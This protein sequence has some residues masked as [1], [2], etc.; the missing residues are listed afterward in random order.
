MSMAVRSS[1]AMVLLLG[2]VTACS[3]PGAKRPLPP[4][5]D[6]DGVPNS[7]DQCPNEAEDYDGDRD[8][9]GCPDFDES[10]HAILDVDDR[11]PIILDCE[12]E[13]IDYDGCPDV[14][15]VFERDSAALTGKQLEI[16]EELAQEL[17]TRKKVERLRIDG[18]FAA[19]ETE[20]VAIRRAE[21]VR[22]RL[23]ADGIP[24][25]MLEISAAAAPA[26]SEGFVSFFALAC[27]Q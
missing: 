2:S 20:A 21:A 14:I 22:Q 6:K 12:E 5:T 10:G 9:D 23:V 3:T 13:F 27:T 8:G 26:G 11:C 17:T 19:G 25:G 1:L 16:I 24:A 15:L 18:Q 4:D 7:V